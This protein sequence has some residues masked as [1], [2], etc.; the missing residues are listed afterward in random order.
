M[1]C[2]IS[3]PKKERKGMETWVEGCRQWFKGR[4]Y[5]GR[6]KRP[7]V[8]RERRGNKA[9]KMEKLCLVGQKLE[10]VSVR[11]MENR[12]IHPF[13]GIFMHISK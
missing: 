11:K 7:R 8:W 2:M 1:E 4:F 9:T 13:L 12:R 6:R 10:E 5:V 3:T